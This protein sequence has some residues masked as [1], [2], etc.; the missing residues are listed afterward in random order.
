[1]SFNVKKNETTLKNSKNE[2]KIM[3]ILTQKS[4]FNFNNTNYNIMISKKFV[5]LQ[6][7]T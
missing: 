5:I 2:D 6:F 4:C 1:M 3:N 7:D